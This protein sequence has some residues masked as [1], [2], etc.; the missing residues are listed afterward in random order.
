MK[1]GFLNKELYKWKFKR[2]PKEW[3][4]EELH[5]LFLRAE[6]RSEKSRKAKREHL[7]LIAKEIPKNSNGEHVV[8][9]T[10]KDD[11][12]F[13]RIKWERE[14]KCYSFSRGRLD[15]NKG[16]QSR[17]QRI[18]FIIANDKS[19]EYGEKMFELENMESI[20]DYKVFNILWEVVTSKLRDHFNESNKIPKNIFTVSI[21]SYKYYV[22]TEEKYG[23]YK[24]FICG[25]LVSDDVVEIK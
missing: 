21:G 2:D 20:L 15:L 12:C 6:K 11:I 23:Y 4:L 3:S 5:D 25:G 9:Y 24:K 10:N 18:E 14:Y 1:V 22:R 13:Y 8:Y 7:K 19:F 17:E 16:T